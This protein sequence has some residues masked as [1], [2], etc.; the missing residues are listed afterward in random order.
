MTQTA[1]GTGTERVGFLGFAEI[2]HAD[3]IDRGDELWVNGQLASGGSAQAGS[4]VQFGADTNESST[5]PLLSWVGHGV[6]FQQGGVRGRWCA[7]H[8]QVAIDRS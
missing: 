4:P 8:W 3:V 5:P 7:G 2:A 1:P 6:G